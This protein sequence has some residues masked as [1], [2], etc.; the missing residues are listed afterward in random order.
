MDEIAPPS[1]GIMDPVMN[2]AAGEST[3]AAARPNS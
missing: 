3:K 1:I 2:D